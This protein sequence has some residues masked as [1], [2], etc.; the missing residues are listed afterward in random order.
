[1]HQARGDKQAGIK[2][3][4][5]LARGLLAAAAFMAAGAAQAVSVTSASPSGEVAQATQL[6]LQF[7][8][9]VVP[10]GDLRQA[11]PA[12]LRCEGKVDTSGSGHWASEREWLFELNQPLPPGAACRVSLKPEFKPGAEWTGAREFRF[13]LGAPFLLDARPW[14]SAQIAEDQQFLLHFNGAP[15]LASL[16]GR[17]WCEVEGLGERMP[18][19]LQP[20]AA[21]DAA[22]KTQSIWGNERKGEWLLLACQRPLPPGARVRIV[23]GRGIAAALNPAVQSRADQ[24]LQY[25]VRQPLTAEFHCTRERAEE[26]CMPILPMRLDFSEQ[27][28]AALA[29]KARLKPI[30]G[31]PE[32]APVTSKG[33]G[34]DKD[35]RQISFPTPLPENQSFQ[36]VLPPG[37]KDDAGRPLSNATMFPLTVRTGIAPPIAKFAVAS[38]GIVEREPEGPALVPLTLRHVQ[39]ELRPGSSAGQMLRQRFDGSDLE[40]LKAYARVRELGNDEYKSR[41]APMLDARTAKRMDLP[42]LQGGDPRPFEVIGVPISEPGFHVL[43]LRSQRLGQALLEPVA[44]MYVRTSVLVTNLGLHFKLGRESSL[45]WVTTLD[46]AQPVANADISVMDCHGKPIWQ[47]RSNAQGLARIDRPLS[48]RISGERCPADTGLFVTA[49]AGGELAFLFTSWQRGIE[50]W[51]FNLPVSDYEWS[52]VRTHTVLDRTL[53]RAGETVSMKHFIRMENGQGLAMIRPEDLPSEVGVSHQGSGQEGRLPL[54][55]QGHGRSASSQWA[56]P[57][58][59]KLGAYSI[60]LTGKSHGGFGGTFRVEEF[61]VP[62]VDARINVPA[63]LPAAPREI[64]L[65]AQL[66]YMAGGGMARAPLKLSALLQ[67]RESGFAGFEDFSFAPPRSEQR[68]ND[69]GDEQDASQRAARLVADK[70][71]AVTDAQGAAQLS[72]AKLPPLQQPSDL[73][74]ELAYDDPNGERQTVSRRVPLWPA[75]VVAGIKASHWVGNG[76]QLRFQ[77]LALATDGK[78]LAGQKIVVRARL[79]QWLSSR[80]RMV[81]GF[82]A[83][84]NKLERKELGEVCSGTTDAKGLLTCEASLTTPGQVELIARA[85]DADGHASEAA[86]PVWV[87]RQGEFWF[88][89]NNDDRIE[90]ITEKR[91]YEPG[92]TARLQV[93]MPF[94][95]ATA[96]VAIEREGVIETRLV[97]LRGRD[98][99]IEL[100]VARDWSPNVYVSVLAVRGRIREVPW[101]S[102]FSWG[103][104]SPLQWWRDWR[105]SGDY[106]PP[107]AMVDLGKPAYKLGIA[108]FEVGLARHELKVEVTSDKPQYGV[109]QKALA[110]VRVTQDGKPVPE[111]ELAFA[112]VDEGLLALSDNASWDLLHAMLPNRPLAVETSTAQGEIVGRRHYGRKAIAAGGGGGKATRELFDT[113]LLWK[114]LIKLDAKGE[115]QIEVPLNDSLTSF[116][117]VAV[118]DAGSHRFGSGHAVV[119]VSQDL[120]MLSGLPPLLREGDKLQAQITVRNASSREMKL[121][122]ALKGQVNSNALNGEIARSAL[123]LPAQEL[124]LAAGSARELS[125]PL[126]VPMGAFSIAWEGEAFELGGAAQDRVKLSQL[127]Q[128]AVPVRVLQSTLQQLDAAL[129]IPVASPA[130]ALASNGIKRGGLQIG[131]QPRLTGALPGLKRFFESYPYSCLEQL[132]SKA[133][134]LHDDARWN[135]LMATL[136]TYL[137]RDGLASYFP[138][139]AGERPMGSDRLTAHLLAAAHEAGRVLPEDSRQRLL[140]GLAGFVEGRVQRRFWAPRADE[141]ARRLAALEALSRYGRAK[142]SML[143]TVDS[144]RINTWPTATLID[145]LNLLRRLPDLAQRDV[146]LAEVQAQLRSRISYAGSTLRFVNEEQDN[147]WWLMESPDANAARLILAVL[148]EPAWKAELPRLLQGHISR[149]QL[150]AWQTTVANLWSVLALEKF[151]A[152]F[153]SVKPTGRSVAQ[154]GAQQ[155]ALEWARQAEGGSLM[156]AW[157]EQA[158][159]LPLQVKQEGA[160]KPW[161]TVQSLAAIPIK[162]PLNA[163]YRIARSVQAIEQKDKGRWSRG[164]VMR[165]RLEIDASADMSWVVIND[166]VP[167]G[168]SHLGTGLGRDSVIATQG[169]KRE[170]N[171]FSEAW[172]AYEERG[173]EAWRAYYAYLPR[174]KHVIEYTVRLN[175][176]GR[177]QMPVSRVEAMY[178][179]ERFGEFPNATLEVGP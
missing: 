141:D 177:F 120:Q 127:V 142:A 88:A 171:E 59:A 80:K 18:A 116:R 1:M 111:A 43:E 22:L 57:P 50:S 84:D 173:F 79:Q 96:L 162:A 69:E 155:R 38:F 21:R 123:S 39:G 90:V 40:L 3:W 100:P 29:Q 95:E 19:Q 28:P 160:G 179:P 161:L 65:G 6:R 107:T 47:G 118:A 37:M 82:Y 15:D 152:R 10:L 56:I 62:L 117:L 53:F 81:G 60:A 54:T 61:R 13:Q 163:G 104:R 72:I 89:Q 73:L 119:R 34:A 146:K 128:P 108:A 27:V 110:K 170:S 130:D 52:P 58:A 32:I 87:T 144:G 168:A 106:Q 78:P 115:A 71:P 5:D 51:R 98:P 101:Y 85:Q 77:A 97:Q 136:P 151:S 70:Q 166:P 140:D 17:I 11:D 45:A 176:A 129:S 48:E 2:R 138:I 24:H 86:A 26:P 112:A 42:V 169:E 154:L 164:D 74:V 14:N 55:W 178:A 174:G 23:W 9:A 137:D 91:R 133:M 20:L 7:S 67:P 105:A 131:L 135:A 145:W 126:E 124:T 109:R 35:V 8:E 172:V 139:G 148:D 150:G 25:K 114:P 143:A 132:S 41:K 30:G 99:V 49:R 157:P 76:Q 149:Q 158:G 83:Y 44:P 16:A 156:L 4:Q 94:R 46:R 68:A 125:W 165:I 175:S 103:W 93:R 153:E 31:G 159:P 113:L 12:S 33:D 63:T 134:A 122:V 102:F 64:K 121:K 147:W 36:L 75:R 66:N 167:A 92:E